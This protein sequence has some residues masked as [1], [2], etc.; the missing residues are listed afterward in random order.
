MIIY[1]ITNLING[2]VYIG[3]TI[4]LLGTRWS[5]HYAKSSNYP[6]LS[7]A[8][9]KYGKENFTIKE[10][11]IC[12]S[13]E[14]L[15]KKEEYWI[16]ELD[17]INKG[18][19]LCEGGG[20]SKGYKHTKESRKKMSNARKGKTY[21]EIYGKEQAVK[22]KIKRQDQNSG[23]NN[24]NYGKIGKLNHNYGKSI[25]KKAKEAFNRTNQARM[26]PIICIE[27]GKVYKS[28]MECARE[29][30]LIQGNIWKVLQGK[31][32][33]TGNYTFKYTGKENGK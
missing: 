16:K 3:Q 15:N 31:R 29:M 4:H 12:N 23:K 7:N 13:M 20:N 21:E 32:N 14:E 1:K 26:T 5:Q 11:E 28:T 19:N 25:N 30:N 10:L 6:K 24:I 8:I 2:K 27:T 9:K 18:Y 33:H 17:S 22:I